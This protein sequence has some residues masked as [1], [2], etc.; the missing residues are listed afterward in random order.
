MPGGARVS[1]ESAQIMVGLTD[2][3][4]VVRLKGMLLSGVDSNQQFAKLLL[5]AC[6]RRQDVWS[7]RTFGRAS[8]R[9]QS[10]R[11]FAKY[12]VQGR[13]RILADQEQTAAE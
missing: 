11:F 1:G 9:R 5:G 8:A 10:V 7:R 12:G 6:H 4:S 2:L 3:G 13:R